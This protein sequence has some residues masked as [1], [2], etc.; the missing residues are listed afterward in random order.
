MPID[1][2]LG[3]GTVLMLRLNHRRSKDIDI[4]LDDPQLLGM[5]N[6]RMSD[7]ALS[8]TPTSEMRILERVIEIERPGEVIAKKMWHRGNRATARDLLD[9]I[10]V[11]DAEPAEIEMAMPYLKRHAPTFLAQVVERRGILK[12]EFDAID[13]LDVSRTCDQC[14]EIARTNLLPDPT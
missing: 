2:S 12:S 1:W 11:A 3:G 13:R 7:A 5:F 4:L 9:F 14:V 6:P 10:A 8:V